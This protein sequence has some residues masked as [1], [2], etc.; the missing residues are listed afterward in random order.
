[1]PQPPEF[2]VKNR[3]AW[4]T[5]CWITVIVKLKRSI[6]GDELTLPR[7]DVC[8]QVEKSRPATN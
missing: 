4:R 1:L 2:V 6:C 8:R 7:F 5:V 3:D